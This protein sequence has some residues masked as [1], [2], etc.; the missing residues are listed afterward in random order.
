MGQLLEVRGPY[1]CKLKAQGRLSGVLT[2]CSQT[3]VLYAEHMKSYKTGISS[4]KSDYYSNPI[5][6]SEGTV[7]TFFL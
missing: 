5:T 3:D 4:D 7:K 6:H 2:S 1:L